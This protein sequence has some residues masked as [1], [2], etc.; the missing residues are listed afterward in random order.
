[1]FGRNDTLDVAFVS[2]IPMI[3][4]TVVA[5]ICQNTFDPEGMKCRL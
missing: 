1:M 2:C 5:G 3:R 4:F